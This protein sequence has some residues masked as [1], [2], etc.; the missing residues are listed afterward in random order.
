VSWIVR[1]FSSTIVG[2]Q[3]MTLEEATVPEDGEI[4]KVGP[5]ARWP[6]MPWRMKKFELQNTQEYLVRTCFLTSCRCRMT[7]L[8]SPTQGVGG[9][10][11]YGSPDLKEE[12]AT[13]TPDIAIL[14]S[15]SASARVGF[16]G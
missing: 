6:V 14:R 10:T 11:G 1:A 2:F 7:L 15:D 3:F 5:S 16:S 12:T 4:P 8:K 13:V 9:D